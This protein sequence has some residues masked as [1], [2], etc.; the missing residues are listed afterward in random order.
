[1]FWKI[2]FMNK[3]IVYGTIRNFKILK[4]CREEIIKESIKDNK[5]S[6]NNYKGY[7]YLVF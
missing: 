4:E 1:M 3:N 7:S 2:I 5:I 6:K